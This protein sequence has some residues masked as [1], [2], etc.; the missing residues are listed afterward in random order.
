M[1]RYV[2]NP[3]LDKP[4]RFI[5]PIQLKSI[6]HLLRESFSDHIDYIILFGGSLDLACG[7]DS[8]L[9]L[10][11]ISEHDPEAVY[12]EIYDICQNLGRPFDILV[13]SYEDFMSEASVF[14]TVEHRILQEGLCLY[15]K[16]QDHVTRAS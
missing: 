14:G 7:M 3:A 8:D 9:D 13:S 16:A 1:Q 6:S 15:A 12:K 2:F 10:Y 11:V 5:H 4:L